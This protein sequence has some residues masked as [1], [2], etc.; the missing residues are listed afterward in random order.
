MDIVSIGPF[1]GDLLMSIFEQ[2]K[3]LY[4]SPEE[5]GLKQSIKISGGEIKKTNISSRFNVVLLMLK[6]PYFETLGLNEFNR[7]VYWLNKPIDDNQLSRMAYWMESIYDI[8]PSTNLLLECVNH[9]AEDKKF[10]PLI[11]YFKNKKW[12]EKKRLEFLLEKQFGAEPSQLTR[13]YSKKFFIGAIR[14]AIKSTLEKPVKHDCVLVLFGRQ[15]LKKSTAIE[16]LSIRNEWFGDTPLDITNKDYVLHLNGRLLYEMKELARRSKEAEMEKAFLC[17]KIDSLRMPY[18]KLRIDIPRKTSFIATT[19]RLDILNDATGSR[20]WWPVMCGYNWDE[21]GNM[22]EW[23]SNKTIDVEY[24]REN[25][26][27]IWLEALHYANDPKQ[28]HWLDQGEEKLRVGGREAF[29]SRHPWTNTVKTIIQ[30]FH[31]AGNHYFQLAEIV[32]QMDLNLNQKDH[33]TRIVIESILKELGYTKKKV[34]IGPN[35]NP[36]WRWGKRVKNG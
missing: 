35:E 18:G 27:Q 10:N 29:V 19:N 25:I 7:L 32:T 1:K 14:R 24:I 21:F 30:N 9:V 36:V 13:A 28:I 5:L 17:S 23:E 8:R 26:D 4:V 20:R 6:H 3:Q 33:K 11:E 2:S 22:I 12:D 15:G 16:A 31:D 34:R